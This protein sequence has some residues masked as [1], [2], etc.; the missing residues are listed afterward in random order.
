MRGRRERMKKGG[1]KEWREGEKRYG[2]RE[3]KRRE[4]GQERCSE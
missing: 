2:E 3:R 4:G 1:R